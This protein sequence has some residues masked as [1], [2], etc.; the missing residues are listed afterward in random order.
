MAGE[1]LAGATG[2]PAATVY[3][4]GHIGEVFILAAVQ[5]RLGALGGRAP[6][7]LRKRFTAH[8][9]STLQKLREFRIEP[10]GLHRRSV[11]RSTLPQ[12]FL[13]NVEP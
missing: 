2:S 12:C 5:Q 6:D 1:R 13:V 7:E 8:P 11:S 3:G 4:S 9:R 10:K